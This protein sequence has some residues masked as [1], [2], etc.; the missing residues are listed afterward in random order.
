MNIIF[1]IIKIFI[2]IIMII[3]LT[4]L[5]LDGNKK[6][7]TFNNGNPTLNKCII[8]KNTIDNIIKENA[9]DFLDAEIAVKNAELA[10]ETAKTS[11]KT[12][13]KYNENLQ[14]AITTLNNAKNNKK[15]KTS[16]MDV[17]NVVNNKLT[18]LMAL[19]ENL[20][21]QQVPQIQCNY[22]INEI[23]N[24]L[25]HVNTTYDNLF[26]LRNSKL[27]DLANKNRDVTVTPTS[28]PQYA[29]FVKELNDIQSDFNK[30]NENFICYQNNALDVYNKIKNSISALFVNNR[31]PV[32]PQYQDDE[33][34]TGA[35][36]S[37]NAG[38]VIT[39]DEM[40]QKGHAS[41]A[42]TMEMQEQ[43]PEGPI[44]RSI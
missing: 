37:K 44:K 1:I 26:K 9:K 29:K 8:Y 40:R 22:L 10:L 2:V 36:D 23:L 18:E 31:V 25:S 33:P 39:T 7:E 13:L 6:I 35:P 24:T 28:S 27:S 41:M 17:M 5:F 11:S 3:L 30:V 34:G 15:C 21:V 38:G 20:N 43:D 19:N 16:K 12:D 32:A 14:N 4:L 42:N